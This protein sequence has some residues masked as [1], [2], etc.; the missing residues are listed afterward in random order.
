MKVSEKDPLKMV[1]SIKAEI[2]SLYLQSPTQPIQAH[3]SL[4][5]H[6][7]IKYMLKLKNKEVKLMFMIYLPNSVAVY[8]IKIST[9][10]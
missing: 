1:L 3:I 9:K 7:H 10:Q 6:S 2:S 4:H 8:K 5:V